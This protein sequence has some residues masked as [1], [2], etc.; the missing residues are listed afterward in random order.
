MKHRIDSLILAGLMLLAALPRASGDQPKA[1]DAN[2]RVLSG[3]VATDNGE[4]SVKGKSA[5][6]VIGET[7]AAEFI[8]AWSTAEIQCRRSKTG[9]P[10]EGGDR[11]RHCLTDVKDVTKGGAIRVGIGRDAAGH[12]LKVSTSAAKKAGPGGDGPPDF[13]FWPALTAKGAKKSDALGE[14]GIKPRSW[15]NRWLQLRVDVRE[16]TLT[17]WLEGLLVK[18]IERLVI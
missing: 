8:Q 9:K 18:Q 14:A 12:V 7:K 4:L 6:V 16:R 2:F 10:G 1:P 15:Q 5:V 11:H 3:T 17:V 13:T